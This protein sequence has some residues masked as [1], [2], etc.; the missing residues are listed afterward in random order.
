[1]NVPGVGAGNW[2]WRFRPEQMPGGL[3]ERVAALTART[4]RVP[5]AGAKVVESSYL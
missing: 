2:E 5:G 4:N 1:M 3:V